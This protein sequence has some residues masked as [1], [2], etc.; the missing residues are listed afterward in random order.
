MTIYFLAE[1]GSR[2]EIPPGSSLVGRK[3]RITNVVPEV[4]LTPLDEGRVVS[5]RHAQVEADGDQC[6]LRDLG[7]TNGT[8][9]NGRRVPPSVACPLAAGDQVSFGGIVVTLAIEG[10][11]APAALEAAES[12]GTL[13]MQPGADPVC[14]THPDRPPVGICPECLQPYCADCLGGGRERMICARCAA[15][16]AGAPA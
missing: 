8:F 10:V 6:Q 4:D 5:R 11:E 16:L 15:M 2:I 1:N 7:S 13:V 12:E 3:D 9:V 14:V